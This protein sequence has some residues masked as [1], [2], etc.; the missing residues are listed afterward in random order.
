MINSFSDFQELMEGAGNL[1]GLPS[2]WIASLKRKGVIGE[3]S[4]IG[5]AEVTTKSWS[6]LTGAV[7][8]ALTEA[9][10]G[11][12][13][14][15]VAIFVNDAP[16]LLLLANIGLGGQ[17]TTFSAVQGDGA[18]ITRRTAISVRDWAAEDAQ[19]MRMIK[20]GYKPYSQKIMKDHWVDSKDHPKT[21]IVDRI[22]S[23]IGNLVG[24]DVA[25]GDKSPITFTVKSI[26]VDKNRVAVAKER[27]ANKAAPK[28][29]AE[30][31]SARHSLLKKKL[32]DSHE[33]TKHLD[34]WNAFMGT[35]LTAADFAEQAMSGN[36]FKIDKNKIQEFIAAAET[37]G[38]IAAAVKRASVS[39]DYYSNTNASWA[40]HKLRWVEAILQPS[41]GSRW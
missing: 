18:A 1:S 11:N 25:Q 14:V 36:E 3:N 33:L 39:D 9:E 37:L 38:R 4:E 24:V 28:V 17:R 6:A 5:S 26:K 30:R 10:N 19:R 20:A 8:K 15:G 21:E 27:Q 16:A 41:S 35:H 31:L 7:K 32:V 12:G 22:A 34:A 29:S 23:T 13:V 40:E 2:T